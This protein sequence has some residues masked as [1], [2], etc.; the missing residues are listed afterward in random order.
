MTDNQ[1][2]TTRRYHDAVSRNDPQLA[3]QVCLALVS[4]GPTHGWALSGLLAS[5][6]DIGRI[7]SLSRPLTYRALDQLVADGLVAR[8]GTAPGGGRSRTL[9]DA[10]E[11]G[12]AANRAWLDRPV[13][14]P[15]D[16]RSEL[17]L[18]LALRERAGLALAP[19]AT[20]QRRRFA[21]MFDALAGAADSIP[22]GEGDFVARWRREHLIAI[23]RFLT[24]FVDPP[25]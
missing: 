9:V 20:A 5:D 14:L 3:G 13:E 22:A 23:D 17:L 24:S 19:L 2:L 6:G 10:T 18:K 12:L 7:W 21:P 4:E 1:D 25:T 11:A 16:V 8:V 15:R